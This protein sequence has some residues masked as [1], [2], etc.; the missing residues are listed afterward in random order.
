MSTYMQRTSV[1]RNDSLIISNRILTKL[2]NDVSD[3]L[4]ACNS[5]MF[6]ISHKKTLH[7]SVA[8]QYAI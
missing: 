4:I 5:A 7:G 3:L 6:Q 2:N 1:S 8:M